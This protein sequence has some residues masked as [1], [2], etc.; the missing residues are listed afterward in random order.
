MAAKERTVRIVDGQD[1]R[2]PERATVL[3]DDQ[4]LHGVAAI[5]VEHGGNGPI[6]Q[7][8]LTGV[9]EIHFRKIAPEEPYV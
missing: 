5:R 9:E 8:T 6:V 1:P 2:H 7:L 4:P 3:V